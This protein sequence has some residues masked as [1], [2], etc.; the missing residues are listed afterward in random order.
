MSYVIWLSVSSVVLATVWF[1]YWAAKQIASLI[2]ST[3]KEMQRQATDRPKT[4]SALGDAIDAL[5]IHLREVDTKVDGCY[6]LA[7][8]NRAKITNLRKEM[9]KE[10][11]GQADQAGEPGATARL[12]IAPRLPGRI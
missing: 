7:R 1:V 11:D 8:G 12:S 5:Q 4:L 9:G 10:S 6:S 2:Q 3:I